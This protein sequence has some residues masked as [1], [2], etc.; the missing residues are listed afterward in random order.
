MSKNYKII[1]SGY[2]NQ[3]NIYNYSFYDSKRDKYGVIVYFKDRNYLS[4]QYVDAKCSLDYVFYWNLKL[5]KWQN[6]YL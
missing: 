1:E 5:T 2:D 3:N 6:I 4:M